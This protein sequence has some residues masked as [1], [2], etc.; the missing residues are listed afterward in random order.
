M[1][2]LALSVV[3][4]NAQAFGKDATKDAEQ[5]GVPPVSKAS[6]IVE[7][8]RG[9]TQALS[10]DGKTKYGPPRTMLLKRILSPAKNEIREISVRILKRTT[11]VLT[12]TAI[13][14]TYTLKAL[15]ADHEGTVKFVGEPWQW[16]S[17][18]YE[19]DGFRLG[20]RTISAKRDT[21]SLILE[22]LIRGPRGKPTGRATDRL[23]KVTAE[24]YTA[25]LR[26][27]ESKRGGPNI[28]Y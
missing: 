23:R 1:G 24:A 12:G 20:S 8:F 11:R 22:H 7:Y 25:A 21:E 13:P 15:P 26:A 14:D 19:I 16:K 4:L 27:W 2:L 9:T 3:L 18:V 5:S 6:D 10:F 17:W 28:P